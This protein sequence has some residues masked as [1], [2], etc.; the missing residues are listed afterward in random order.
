VPEIIDSTGSRIALA[1]V[2]AF[3]SREN[4]KIRTASGI[5]VMTVASIMARMQRKSAALGAE[6]RNR[7]TKRPAAARRWR[8]RPYSESGASAARRFQH[9]GHAVEAMGEEGILLC[10]DHD[11]IVAEI[12]IDRAASAGARCDMARSFQPAMS[13]APV[14]PRT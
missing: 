2:A 6:A 10:R 5:E 4:S 1:F 8:S 3:L 11:A 7:R 13:V 14:R 9:R 12:G